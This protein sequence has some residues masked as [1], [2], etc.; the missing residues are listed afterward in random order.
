[1]RGVKGVNPKRGASK[2]HA[3]VGNILK[4]M[5]GSALIVYQEV[6]VKE[7]DPSWS[8]YRAKFDWVIPSLRLVIECHGQQ[9]FKAGSW[10]KDIT[11]LASQMVRD[12]AKEEAA[13][14]G[15]YLWYMI[16][17]ETTDE[18]IIRQLETV[19]PLIAEEKPKIDPKKA[20]QLDMQREIRK[21]I[22]K[23][24]RQRYK[25]SPAAQARKERARE[26][27]REARSRR[28]QRS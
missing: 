23:A 12:T 14:R 2:L 11:D 1:M 3:R 15:K 4:T 24:A 9:H 13:R 25:D 19:A 5:F 20:R 17:N 26:L 21:R 28:K 18:A 8:D 22:S 10:R 27:R 6:P 16:T 7:I